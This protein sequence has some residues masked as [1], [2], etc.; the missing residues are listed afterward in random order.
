MGFCST[1]VM[2]AFV[3]T[4]INFVLVATGGLLLVGCTCGLV[5]STLA[6]DLWSD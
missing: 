1:G 2:I 4:E 3:E 5:S 6:R